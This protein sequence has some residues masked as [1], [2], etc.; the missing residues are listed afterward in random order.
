[1]EALELQRDRIVYLIDLKVEE[2]VKEE[3]LQQLHTLL[4]VKHGRIE[5]L[6]LLFDE[7]AKFQ[8]LN[9]A[10]SLEIVH[11]QVLNGPLLRLIREEIL[12]MVMISTALK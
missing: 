8:W 11:K 5:L 3:L 4:E 1:M 12:H 6:G 2:H 10:L 7:G 9:H